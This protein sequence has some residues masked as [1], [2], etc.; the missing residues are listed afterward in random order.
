MPFPPGTP[1]VTLVGTVPTA[2]TGNGYGGKV[3]L[4]PSAYLIDAQRNALYPNGP[5]TATI[6]NGT[7]TATLIPCDAAGIQPTGWRWHIDIQPIG[8][9]RYAYYANITGTGTVDIT[10]ITPVPA[11]AGGTGSGPVGPTGPAGP[12]GATGATGAQGPQGETG[13]AGPA[14]PAGGTVRTAT[15]RINDGAVQDLPSAPSWT[16]VTTSVGTP[17]QCSIAAVAGDRITADVSM[18]ASGTRFFDIALLTSG[19]AIALYDSSGTSSPS[20]EGA[21]WMYYNTSFPR[22]AGSAQFTISAGHISGGMVTVALVNQGTSSAK[23]YAYSGYPWIMRLKNLGP[24]P[25]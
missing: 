23:V 11:P 22:V 18:L 9:P 24:E 15:A 20:T 8:A 4:T 6:T 17:L 16:I 19:G 13:P 3:I 5:V 21:P 7:F 12:T 10:D 25:A 2:V 1:T 14:G